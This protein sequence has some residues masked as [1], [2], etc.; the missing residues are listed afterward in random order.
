MITRSTTLHEYISTLSPAEQAE[1]KS[2]LFNIFRANPWL[3]RFYTGCLQIL[4]SNSNQISN[5]PTRSAIFSN[6]DPK[7]VNSMP[8]NKNT[9]V[10]THIKVN[11]VPCGSPAL[12]GEVFC[13]FHQRMIR[14]VRTPGKSRLHPIALIENEEGIQ[15][16]LMEI[17]NALI[18]NTIDLRRAQLVLRA[19]HIAVKNSPRVHFDIYKSDMIHEVPNY[20]A[21]PAAQKPPSPA[22]A[23]AGALAR[24]PR[25]KPVSITRPRPP[26]V[27]ARPEPARP[28]PPAAVK[29]APVV[30]TAARSL[31]RNIARR[32]SG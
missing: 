27:A 21:V 31:V 20:P 32:R 5:L 14:G 28:K 23:Q 1:A 30:R 19:L 29:N 12:R 15:A 10:C 25:P 3:S 9:R 26:I 11:G 24:I 17:I 16:S 2:H 22:L 4:S 18:R 13:Y 8:V 7:G 6:P